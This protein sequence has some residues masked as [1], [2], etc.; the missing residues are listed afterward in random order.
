MGMRHPAEALAIEFHPVPAS[1][2]TGQWC[3]ACALPSGL[4][5]I[6]LAVVF[7]PD[8]MLVLDRFRC[9]TCEDCGR[10]CTVPDLVRPP[11]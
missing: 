7:L 4:L 6:V 1:V 3:P 8:E 2:E 9:W 10:T 11:G 5:V